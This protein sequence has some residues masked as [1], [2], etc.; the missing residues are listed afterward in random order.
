MPEG[1]PS[2]YGG[3]ARGFRSTFGPTLELI[4]KAK[5]QKQL[6]AAAKEELEAKKTA[7]YNQTV[8]NAFKVARQGGTDLAEE[9]LEKTGKFQKGQAKQKLKQ[10]LQ[11]PEEM[12]GAIDAFSADDPLGGALLGKAILADPTKAG[13]L[14]LKLNE[15]KANKA[16][17]GEI[18][19]FMQ[20]FLGQGPGAPQP[21]AAIPSVPIPPSPEPG[22]QGSTALAQRLLEESPM[23]APDAPQL[24]VAPPIT[25]EPGIAPAGIGAALPQ[26]QANPTQA[27]IDQL[28]RMSEGLRLGAGT[29]ASPKQAKMWEDR[30]TSVEKLRDALIKDMERSQPKIGRFR[31]FGKG[32]V[33]DTTTGNITRQPTGG[34]EA[35]TINMGQG[36]LGVVQG[37]GKIEFI[38][39]P[40]FRATGD[41]PFSVGQGIVAIPKGDGT[42]TFQQAPQF[43]EER[44]KPFSVGQGIVATP[45][46]DGTLKFDAAPGFVKPETPGE[47]K[48]RA[49]ETEEEKQKIA[50]K[51]AREKAFETSMGNIKAREG[52]PNTELEKRL[53]ALEKA[54]K[55]GDEK[56]IA[57]HGKSLEKYVSSDSFR[58]RLVSSITAVRD[59]RQEDVHPDFRGFSDAELNAMN[60][61]PIRALMGA[62]STT[63]SETAKRG[64][65]IQEQINAKKKVKTPLTPGAKPTAAPTAATRPSPS[66]GADADVNQKNEKLIAETLKLLPNAT[67]EQLLDTLKDTTGWMKGFTK[68]Q[69]ERVVRETQREMARRRKLKQKTP[70][71]Q[72]QL[73]PDERA[74]REAFSG[75][76]VR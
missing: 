45:Q 33:V 61:D 22:G 6:D 14:F 36:I 30:A 9:M 25:G 75:V 31:G 42:L 29:A 3:F 40:Q 56:V 13:E 57:L 49:I 38:Q 21:Q 54:R 62:L 39:A 55:S 2:G 15:A 37:N 70:E 71:P 19:K 52:L 58:D 60:I 46:K 67:D 1:F 44:T 50:L 59:G 12:Q 17:H 24:P 34:G 53:V 20:E 28:S 26:P 10:L 51:F 16:T 69:R 41:K 65:T 66:K 64:P 11:L 4:Q 76:G 5:R 47:K 23:A 7:A 43:Q 74:R 68:E 63:P 18:S 48:T 27:K 73:T 35:K 32:G 72:S 8:M